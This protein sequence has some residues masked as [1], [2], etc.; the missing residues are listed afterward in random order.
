MSR[1]AQIHLLHVSLIVWVMLNVPLTSLAQSDVSAVFP[2]K[3]SAT[4]RYFVDQRDKPFRL[5]SES[6]WFLPANATLSEV[7]TYLADRKAKGFTAFIMMAMVHQG[8]YPGYVSPRAPNTLTG[9]A[10]FTTPG[11]FST[12]NEPYWRF[13]DSII[14]KAA[15]K[16]MVVILAFAYLGYEGGDQGWWGEINQPQ[17][18]QTV[19]YNYGVWLGKRY[20]SRKNIIWYACGDYVPPTGSEGSRRAHKMVEGIKSVIPTALF[21]AEMQ[22]PD[23]LSTDVADFSSVMDMNSFYGY[24]PKE[25]GQTYQTADRAWRLSPSK[26]VWIGEPNYE[27]VPVGGNG[28][29]VDIRKGQYWSVLGGG[30]AGQNFGT[31]G[32]WD[33]KPG[34]WPT[35]LN[36]PGSLDMQRMFSL[37]ATLPWYEMV[38]TGTDAGFLGKNLVPSGQG[39]GATFIAATATPSGSWLLAYVPPSGG[40]SERTFS[41]D[42]TALHAP[43]RARWY[44]PT[45]GVYTTIGTGYANIGTRSFTTA[46]DNGSGQ[47]DWVLVMD[48]GR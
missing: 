41:I 26:P 29:R 39:S 1:V 21:G 4:G 25:N 45:S 14:D 35:S 13:V 18:T 16:E 10:P 46:G 23:G 6:A 32:I 8:H 3:V 11:D 43:A 37:F 34:V 20:K 27:G 7:D 24:G 38:P 28:S 2:L 5:N 15:A 31:E 42:M 12:P 33:F 40:T 36:S 30:I 9:L 19:T 48:A 17:N 47:D 22:T 44:N